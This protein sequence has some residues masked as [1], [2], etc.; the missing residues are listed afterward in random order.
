[1]GQL[2]AIL[3]LVLTGIFLS[4]F[5]VNPQ[6]AI[7]I[8]TDLFF[9]EYVEGSSNNKALEIFNG[10]GA[11]IDLAAGSYKVAFYFNGSTSAGTTIL[12]NGVVLNEDVYVLADKD[13]SSTIP[14]VTDQTSSSNFFNGNDAVALLKGS[15]FIDVIGQIGDAPVTEEW[16]TG[17]TSTENNTLRRKPTIQS[18]DPN[19][20]D[21]FDP[22]I[23]WVGFSKDTFGGLGTHQINQSPQPI[24]EPMTL[25]L[26]GSGLLGLSL[27]QRIKRHGSSSNHRNGFGLSQGNSRRNPVQPQDH[28][29]EILSCWQNGQVS[30]DASGETSGVDRTGGSGISP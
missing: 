25:L 18:G 3:F 21:F 9:S 14:A 12:L 7:A 6:R 8:P 30:P 19:G 24:P 28:P 20:S 2:R 23:E 27:W 10:T 5:L 1:M 22:S 11:S 16:G 26:L 15:T 4:S 17:N 29:R 13:A